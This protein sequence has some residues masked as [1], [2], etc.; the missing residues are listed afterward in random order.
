MA[1]GP[2]GSGT[3][4][5]T[6]GDVFPEPGNPEGLGDHSPLAPASWV[7]GSGMEALLFQDLDSIIS[8][9]PSITQESEGAL[10]TRTPFPLLEVPP[11]LPNLARKAVYPGAEGWQGE[12]SL[13]EVSSH[14]SVPTRRGLWV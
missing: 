3:H 8:N 2:F 4:L 13:G 1:W 6:N 10:P 12:P 5:L 11:I 7:L 14:S 9:P